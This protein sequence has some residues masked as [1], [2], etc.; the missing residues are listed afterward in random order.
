MKKQM[1]AYGYGTD[2][3]VKAPLGV[4][5]A[6]G[7][8]CRFDGRIRRDRLDFAACAGSLTCR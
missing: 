5:A 6:L 8:A 4:R 1:K 3:P 7:N 2:G